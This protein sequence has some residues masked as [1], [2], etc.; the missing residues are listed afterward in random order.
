M[1]DFD[2]ASE[3]FEIDGL[4]ALDRRFG[5]F[6]GAFSNPSDPLVALAAALTS[7]AAARGD[8]CLDLTN[9][10][11]PDLPAMPPPESWIA[12]LKR[13]P[14]IGNP[15]QKRPL[16]LDDRGRLYLYRYWEYEDTLARE[17]C[18]RAARDES[19]AKRCIEQAVQDVFKGLPGTPDADQRTA[20]A[21][22]GSRGLTVITGGPGSGKTYTITAI[23]EVLRRLNE[24]RPLR[25]MLAAPT[26][27][28]A[29]RL[30]ESMRQGEPG[31]QHGSIPEVT[32]IHRLLQTLPGTTRF[33]HDRSRPLSADAVVVDEASMVDLA[34]MTKLVDAVPSGARLI[35]VGDKNQLASV[36]AGS[37]LGDVCAG[38]RL[39]QGGSHALGSCIV[40][41]TGSYRFPPGSDIGELSR[42]VNSGDA[43]AALEILANPRSGTV[44]WLDTAGGR[45]VDAS[46]RQRILE[47]C[48]PLCRA[49]DPISAL[50]AVN[51]FKILCAHASGPGGVETVN[52]TTE[53]LLQDEG[54]I[55]SGG[56]G[57]P[58][59]SGRPV[60]VT[61]NDHALRVFNGDIGVVLP[62]P[63]TG[64]LFTHFPGTT[65]DSRRF[66]PQRLPEHAT[67]YALTV[68]KSQGSE[69]EDVL[70]RLP[71]HDS[72][73][74]TRELIYTA[75]TRARRRIT[76]CGRAE[77]IAAAIER[78]I[79]RTS[80]LRDALW[81]RAPEGD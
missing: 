26:G 19:I 29:A 28:A 44:E 11:G 24:G 66:L 49:A 32:T 6:I 22:A 9:P 40:E 61:R 67:A 73:I 34:L 70:L 79:R 77:V 25:A 68:H 56:A 8:V 74:L 60:L 12:A 4:S 62:D 21:A 14:A 7:R 81:G 54:A 75:L 43:R 72:P 58:W 17:L 35:L 2:R 3:M 71:D 37:V 63:A 53:R 1:N 76:V 20:A 16:I 18:Q 78:R 57:G 33:R 13:S 55:P 48:R 59:Y 42:A 47:G 38:E 27:K 5:E 64:T 69:F 51:R 65:E 30:Q 41:L 10:L 45:E 46:I 15:G 31:G 80:G 52:R 36:Q 23:L 50:A 39:G